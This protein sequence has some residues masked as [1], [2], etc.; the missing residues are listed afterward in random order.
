MA[1]RKDKGKS[2]ALVPVKSESLA[3]P[4]SAI[5]L[6]NRVAP[7]SSEYPVSYSSTLTAPYDPFADIS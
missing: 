5:D 4:I 2:T 3:Y 6:A 7:F 1:H